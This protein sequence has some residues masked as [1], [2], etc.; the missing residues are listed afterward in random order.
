MGLVRDQMQRCDDPFESARA[1]VPS[2]L[3]DHVVLLP[4]LEPDLE[5]GDNGAKDPV[6][7]EGGVAVSLRGIPHAKAAVVDVM[8]IVAFPIS[9]AEIIAV[10]NVVPVGAPLVEKAAA[11]VKIVEIQREQGVHV[12]QNVP[13]RAKDDPLVNV[14]DPH[15]GK[16]V[17]KV[18][19]THDAF[20]QCPYPHPHQT[21]HSHKNLLVLY[22]A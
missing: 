10:A 20:W 2:H 9:I 4:L 3:K 16:G 13:R 6:C 14:C 19:Y 18:F 5:I 1:S 11:S 8:N 12:P 17:V 22:T 21:S 15:V 7:F